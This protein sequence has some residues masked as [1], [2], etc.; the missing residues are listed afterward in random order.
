MCLL[1]F[2]LQKHSKYKLIMMANRDET[3]NRPTAPADFWP[4]HPDILAGRDLEQM[5]TWLGINKRGKIAALTNY[6]DFSLPETGGQSRGHIVS[7]YLQSNETPEYS[8]FNVLVGSSEEL[9]YYSNIEQKTE[10][11]KNGTHGLSNAFM[12]TPWPKTEAVKKLLCDYAEST[13]EIDVDVLFNMMQ[14]AE[15]FPSE[16]LPDTGVGGELES[17]LSSIFIASK[18]YGTRCTT[19]LLV[20]SEDQ[21]YFEERT[22]KN[23]VFATAQKFSFKIENPT[24]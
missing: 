21:V 14:R 13:N 2:Q 22:F 20:D 19:V 12:N 4:D 24:A 8:G 1:A 11:L 3:Y 23:G 15:R 17:M 7:S 9:Y 10:H 16:Q 6:R 18:E 5:G